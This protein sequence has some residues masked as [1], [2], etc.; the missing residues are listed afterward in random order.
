MMN[1]TQQPPLLMKT[2]TW[3]RCKSQ[4]LL[5][6]H[7]SYCK[8]MDYLF[9]SQQTEHTDDAFIT[10]RS[11]TV[12]RRYDPPLTCWIGAHFVSGSLRTPIVKPNTTYKT[13]SSVGLKRCGC[14]PVHCEWGPPGVQVKRGLH[15]PVTLRPSSWYLF[16]LNILY[17]SGWGPL[18]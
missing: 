5:Q 13:T 1:I 6:N 2:Q 12:H 15:L 17:L 16:S 3:N 7:Q 8:T 11:L 18:L 9:L 10:K 4:I 14:V